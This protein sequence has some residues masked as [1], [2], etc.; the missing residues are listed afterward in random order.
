MRLRRQTRR[1]ACRI[2][3]FEHLLYVYRRLSALSVRVSKFEPVVYGGVNSG[4][5]RYMRKRDLAST[6]LIT[7]Q[8]AAAIKNSS[9]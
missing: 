9:F 2:Y 3:L 4:P 8:V 6:S 7:S 1:R 5:V